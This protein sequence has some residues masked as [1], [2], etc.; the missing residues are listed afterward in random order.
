MFN[1]K[2]LIEANYLARMSQ[3][4]PEIEKLYFQV[5]RIGSAPTECSDLSQRFQGVMAFAHN[6]VLPFSEKGL[7]TWE[8]SNRNYLV[9]QA[10]KNYQKE[11]LRLEFELEKIHR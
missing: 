11:L 4:Y 9:D 1:R 5:D 7:E 10:I 3:L 8:R 6:I 2:Q